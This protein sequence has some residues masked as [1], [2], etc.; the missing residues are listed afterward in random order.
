MLQLMHGWMNGS[1]DAAFVSVNAVGWGKAIMLQQ[2]LGWTNEAGTR[3]R[4]VWGNS[5][6]YMGQ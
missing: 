3:A 4:Y 2:W 6:V 5:K 1:V